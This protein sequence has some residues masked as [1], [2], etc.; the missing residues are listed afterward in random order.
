MESLVITKRSIFAGALSSAI[1][2]CF[3][4]AKIFGQDDRIPVTGDF[5]NASGA[6]CE[7]RSTN[8]NRLLIAIASGQVVRKRNLVVTAAHNVVSNG[9]ARHQMDKL[10]FVLGN[11]RRHQRYRVVET[12]FGTEDPERNEPKDFVVF[13]LEQNVSSDI[14]VMDFEE[15]DNPE[16][17]LPSQLALVS[18][19]GDKGLV[20]QVSGGSIVTKPAQFCSRLSSSPQYR[21]KDLLIHSIDSVSGSSGGAI[22]SINPVRPA[23]PVVHA[24]HTGGVSA[25]L[26]W[27]SEAN[28]EFD[29]ACNFNFA[30][31]VTGNQYFYKIFNDAARATQVQARNVLR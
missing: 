11:E 2:S 28:A 15:S 1:T 9:R 30:V 19:H 4:C 3:A 6:I 29:A 21:D 7:M 26:F 16:A 25:E 20:K 5:Y 18:Y 17:E 14:N 24:I 8:Q 31:R 23:V 12:H 22:V 13:R 27:G 10:V